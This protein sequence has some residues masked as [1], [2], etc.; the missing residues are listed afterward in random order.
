VQRR[1]AENRVERVT[2]AGA[3]QPSVLAGLLYDDTGAR[4][5]PSHADKKGRRYRYYVSGGLVS[6]RRSNAPCG[7]RVPAN[8]L[9]AL[10]EDRL[11]RFLG[12]QSELF[13]AAEPLVAEVA[14]GTDLVARAAE[15]ARRWPGLAPAEKRAILMKVIE[16]ID[17]LPETLGV[18][19]RP[20]VL[21]SAL[22]AGDGQT[23]TQR[24]ENDEHTVTLTIPARLR[25]IGKESRLLIDS[26]D[27]ARRAPDHSLYRLLAQA[28]RYNEMVMRGSG[29]TIAQLAAEAGVCG[30]YFSRVLRLSFLAPEVV[31]AVLRDR[32]PLE[33]SA[34]QL[35]MRTRLPAAWDEQ[36]EA[37]RVD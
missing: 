6:G 9:E 29:K 30:P 7:R 20:A 19:I 16:R 17:L 22:T 2:G 8:D 24:M 3:R 1:L 12:S 10:V 11:R 36:R 34:K 37:L 33:L 5:A 14:E 28:Y 4:M 31:K 13:D 21:L 23:W 25:R 35:S 15:L 27:A 18:Q 32:H 26:A